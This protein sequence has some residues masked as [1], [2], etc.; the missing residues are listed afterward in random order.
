LGVLTSKART[1]REVSP[2]L[3]FSVWPLAPPRTPLI[4]L[5][6]P[7]MDLPLLIQ[8]PTRFTFLLL[9]FPDCQQKLVRT[10]FFV[11]PAFRFFLFFIS[12]PKTAVFMPKAGVFPFCL[13]PRSLALVTQPKTAF[14]YWVCQQTVPSP[15]VLFF[16]NPA[17]ILFRTIP[18]VRP[19]PASLRTT[20]SCSHRLFFSPDLMEPFMGSLIVFLF[21]SSLPPFRSPPQE[22]FF[23]LF[24]EGT[25]VSLLLICC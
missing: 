8:V 23:L 22:R 19:N 15:Q 12:P 13:G 6:L 21:F 2:L 9:P 20:P 14:R 5:Y 1:L 17:I 16:F 18:R 25:S 24:S 11:T 4:L 10:S 7:Y 3:S